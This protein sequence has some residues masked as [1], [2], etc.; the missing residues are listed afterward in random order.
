MRS[1]QHPVINNIDDYSEDLAIKDED[2][3]NV[4][5]NDPYEE[6]D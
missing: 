5:E 6:E 4:N 2:H 1:K 3:M